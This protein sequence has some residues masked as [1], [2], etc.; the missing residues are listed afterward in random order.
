MSTIR[1]EHRTGGHF[2]FYEFEGA[3]SNGR[4][5]VKA[6]YGRIGQAASEVTIYDGDS[7]TEANKGFEKKKTEKLKKGY[8]VVSTNGN[9]AP[10]VAEKKRLMFQLFGQ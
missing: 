6:R 3:E 2:K 10:A 9:V 1:L 4:V 5:T 8:I 7:K